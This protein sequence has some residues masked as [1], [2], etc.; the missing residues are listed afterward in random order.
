MYMWNMYVFLPPD[1]R[2]RAVAVVAKSGGLMLVQRVLSWSSAALSF[3]TF[4]S[5]VYG[6]CKMATSLVRT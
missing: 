5:L 3:S 4:L 2:L 6:G 1:C